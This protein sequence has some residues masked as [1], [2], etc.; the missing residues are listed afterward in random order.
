M[1]LRNW[2]AKRA[3]K[4]I[5]VTGL[6]HRGKEHKITDVSAVTLKGGKVYATDVAGKKHELL[7][8]PAAT[9]A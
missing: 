2:M 4:G 1:K 3:F 8:E 6:D 5:T 9:V 7:V